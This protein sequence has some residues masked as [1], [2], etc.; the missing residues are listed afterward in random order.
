MGGSATYTYFNGGWSWQS[1]CG[2]VLWGT[3]SK[4]G[5]GLRNQAQGEPDHLRIPLWRALP[6]Q[7]VRG[8]Q[9]DYAVILK[10]NSVTPR[11]R[12]RNDCSW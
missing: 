3:C 12:E 11:R 5:M 6:S 1:R 2:C 10:E 4:R 7:R 8:D 9:G